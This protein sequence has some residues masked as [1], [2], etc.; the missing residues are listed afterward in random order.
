[1]PIAQKLFNIINKFAGNANAEAG[2]QMGGSHEQEAVN[3]EKAKENAAAEQG[4]VE[5]EVEQP[6]VG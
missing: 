5:A 4:A 6:E 2:L 3:E 1:M